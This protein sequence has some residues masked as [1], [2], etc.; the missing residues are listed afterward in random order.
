MKE[1]GF[2]TY[3]NAMISAAASLG[4]RDL[5]A[6]DIR[7]KDKSIR[8]AITRGMHAVIIAFNAG[9]TLAE[10]SSMLSNA[11]LMLV[12]LATN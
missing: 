4:H 9:A 10:Q 11:L 7:D 6:Y 2:F 3:Y 8:E 12:T 1:D 5:A